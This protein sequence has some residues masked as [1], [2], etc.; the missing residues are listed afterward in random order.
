MQ[1][2]DGFNAN[3]PTIPT[4]GTYSKLSV[5]KFKSYINISLSDSEKDSWAMWHD[6][7]IANLDEALMAVM[8]QDWRYSV[9][10]QRDNMCYIASLMA[11][12]LSH[13][14]AG[15]CITAR[16]SNVLD[17]KSR[18]LYIYHEVLDG[19]VVKYVNTVS[20]RK[21]RNDW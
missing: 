16:A 2:P 14:I 17:A 19:D 15:M 20:K 13:V 21:T 10:R 11:L 12:D 4:V 9:Q 18:L 3:G 6:V 1:N 8:L 5:V 7:N